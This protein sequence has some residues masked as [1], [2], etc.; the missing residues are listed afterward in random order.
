MTPRQKI[1]LGWLLLLGCGA[2]AN[3]QES[4][5]QYYMPAS[6]EAFMQYYR[7]ECDEMLITVQESAIQ[8][9]DYTY[10]VHTQISISKG[11]RPLNSLVCEMAHNFR[12]SP[13]ANAQI[14]NNKR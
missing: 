13:L 2:L 7:G 5:Y 1:T 3:A 9:R 10:R 4:N 11:V 12:P 14:I 6:D 8:A